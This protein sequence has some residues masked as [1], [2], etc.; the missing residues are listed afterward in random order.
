MCLARFITADEMS[1]ALGIVAASWG[2]FSLAHLPRAQR[3]R[4]R[5]VGTQSVDRAFANVE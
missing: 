2:D 1:L 5:H 3:G 4:S